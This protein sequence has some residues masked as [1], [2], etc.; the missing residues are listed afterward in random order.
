MAKG[1]LN[2]VM[3]IGRLGA[4][5]EMR[6]TPSGQ[7][8]ATFN[9]ATNEVWKDKEG[10]LQE[11]TDWHRVVVWRHLAERANEYL[12]KGSRVYIEGQLQTRSWEDKDNVK[13][14]TTEVVARDMQF[15][16]ARGDSASS[17]SGGGD[18][19]AAPLPADS[20]PKSGDLGPE[21]DLPF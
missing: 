4:D 17:K 19:G 21:D 7:A 1:T 18:T 10:N 9:V 3:L 2:K 15:L 8:V 20:E 16:D 14:Y 5:P 11:R 6:Y 12:K 13:R